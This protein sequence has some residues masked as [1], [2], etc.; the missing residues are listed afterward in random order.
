MPRWMMQFEIEGHLGVE[1]DRRELIFRHP[2][3][4]YDVHVWNHKMAPGVE[5]PLLYMFVLFDSDDLRSADMQGPEHVN[6]FLR[7]LSFATG[8]AFRV[9]RPMC[10]F[11]WSVDVQDQRHGYVYHH[12]PNPDL[13]QLVMN[14]DVVAT[15]EA[16][17]NSDGGDVDVMQA[18]LW[19]SSAV[20]ASG[21]ENQFQ[22]FW[23]CIETL[24]RSTATRARCLIDALLAACPF[25]VA[26]ATRF[27]PTGRT[28]RRRSSSCS[29]GSYLA[30]RSR[31]FGSQEKCAT[32]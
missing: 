11:D 25:T 22:L 26:R 6:K 31:S 19:F 9:R 29:R 4:F 20:T 32:L 2:S 27:R 7:F 23:F 28:P 15:V 1:A 13:P 3:G 24:A 14:D 17:L 18:L 12:F 16:L 8:S 30:T 10:L 21:P 5:T